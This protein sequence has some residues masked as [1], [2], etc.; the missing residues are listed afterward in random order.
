MLSYN[1]Y[2]DEGLIE[3][4]F[5]TSK[6]NI[7]KTLKLI[8]QENLKLETDKNNLICDNSSQK[9]KEIITFATKKGNGEISYSQI[10]N[11]IS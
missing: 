11:I 5:L 1:K 8:E 4:Y 6:Q 9:L 2:P 3:K 10:R 7:H